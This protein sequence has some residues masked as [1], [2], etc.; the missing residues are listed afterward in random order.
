MPWESSQLMLAA[1]NA[2]GSLAPVKVIAGGPGEAAIE[3]H[4]AP[5]GDLWFNSD[6]SGFWNLYRWHDQELIRVVDDEAEYSRAPWNFG[7]AQFGVLETGQAVAIRDYAGKSSLVMVDGLTGASTSLP[8]PYTELSQLKVS[9]HGSTFIA[10]SALD[11]P[12][13][14][15]LDLLT[16]HLVT[17]RLSTGLE[18]A[19]G[20]VSEPLAIS[21]PTSDSATSHALYYSP[22]NP[23][24]RGPADERP[25]L[26]VMSHGGPTA[27]TSSRLS[28]AIQ[29]WTSRGFAVVDVNYRGSTGYGRALSPGT[30]RRAGVWPMSTTA[31]TRPFISPVRI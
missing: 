6:R 10:A 30:G 11:A 4:F 12:R 25:P 3:P 7:V 21:Y 17:L 29:F 31:S 26:I 18:L 27:S 16:G 13:L 23:A 24:Y 20:S 14:I 19:P 1:F 2:D 22:Q 5:G 8:V 9:P 15:R 28:A